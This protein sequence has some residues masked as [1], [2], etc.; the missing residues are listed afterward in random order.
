[1]YVQTI[2]ARSYSDFLFGFR[3]CMAEFRIHSPFCVCSVRVLHIKTKQTNS[4]LSPLE[5]INLFVDINVC[6]WIKAVRDHDISFS[7]E[8]IQ[9]Y[10]PYCSVALFHS[11]SHAQHKGS[12][13]LL[14]AREWLHTARSI[15]KYDCK[16]HCHFRWEKK[17]VSKCVRKYTFYSQAIVQSVKDQNKI[18]WLKM[19]A[20]DFQA[21]RCEWI[22]E[23]TMSEVRMWPM[24]SLLW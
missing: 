12:V 14:N 9:R 3:L 22:A 2:C 24:C 17:T 6:I 8:S 1:M 7:M 23:V 4:S 18:G 19:V 21:Q 16:T 20:T 11:H 13:R 10:G 5:L 15:E